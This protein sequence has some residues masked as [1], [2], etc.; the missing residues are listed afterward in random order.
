[1]QAEGETQYMNKATFIDLRSTTNTSMNVTIDVP[2]N[3][4]PGSE[5]IEISAVGKAMKLLKF[6][7]KINI[8]F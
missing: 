2:K 8:I 6:D 7:L 1:M 5:H 4:V 3:A